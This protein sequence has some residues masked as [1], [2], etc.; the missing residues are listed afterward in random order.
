MVKDA[1]NNP[2]YDKTIDAIMVYND[3]QCTSELDL[4]TYHGDVDWFDVTARNV[5][6]VWNINNLRDAVIVDNTLFLD[7]ESKDVI[8]SV[9]DA[10]KK[11]WWQMAEIVSNY[12]IIRLKTLNLTN[13]KV[14]IN[15]VNVVARKI[16]R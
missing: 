6:H 7:G 12:I 16:N 5:N 9:V 15:N 1:S 11:D 8:A 4:S 14:V 13:H 10:T 2:I 3:N